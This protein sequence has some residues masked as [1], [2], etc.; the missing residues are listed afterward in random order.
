M[1]RSSNVFMSDGFKRGS[2]NG[3]TDLTNGRSK[4]RAE[5]LTVNVAAR[6]GGVRCRSF[7]RRK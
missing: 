1:A 5:D 4:R 6:S 3:R 2:S 7:G